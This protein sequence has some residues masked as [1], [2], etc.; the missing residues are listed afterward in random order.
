MTKEEALI[1]LKYHQEWRMGADTIMLS[2]TV[3]SASINFII[4]YMEK[5]SELNID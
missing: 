3:I 4:E 2:P 1:L 5:Q